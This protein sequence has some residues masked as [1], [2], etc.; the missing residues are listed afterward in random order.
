[1]AVARM[2]SALRSGATTS[3]SPQL[4]PQHE[5]EIL[6]RDIAG[7][8]LD[9]TAVLELI[10][11]R[12]RTLTNA[13]GTAIALEADGSMACVASSGNAPDVGV[14]LNRLV[15]LSGECVRTG[16]LVHCRDTQ[17]DPRVDPATCSLLNLRSAAVVPIRREDRVLGLVE[18]LS[19]SPNAFRGTD[20]LLL[21]E[22]AELIAALTTTSDASEIVTPECR[23]LADAGKESA[24]SHVEPITDHSGPEVEVFEPVASVSTATSLSNV[25]PMPASDYQPATVE[26]LPEPSARQQRLTAVLRKTFVLLSSSRRLVLIVCFTAAL[27]C[28]AWAAYMTG[29][30][31]SRLPETEPRLQSY[32][33]APLRVIPGR[34]LEG[35][36]PIY[37]EAARDQ[38]LRGTVVLRVHVGKDGRVEQVDVVRGNPVLAAA[39]TDAVLHWRYQPFLLN[40]QPVEGEIV[41]SINLFPPSMLG[42]P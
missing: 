16:S 19:S 40:D 21:Q 6:K 9:G 31:F 42:K 1:M 23:G 3:G 27:L 25:L 39:A 33:P 11:Q 14:T 41:V 17:T 28:A 13:S 20:V 34:L 32:T 10:V 8:N 22:V 37:P 38:D 2:F 36:Q 35:G 29:A 24:S 15:G 18:I 12:V 5:V 26:P 7:Q 30:I 4:R